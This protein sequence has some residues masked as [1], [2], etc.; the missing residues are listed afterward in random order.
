MILAGLYILYR[1]LVVLTNS[2]TPFVSRLLS[3]INIWNIFFG[4]VVLMPGLICILLADKFKKKKGIE[5]EN[6]KRI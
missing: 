1:Y 2:E 3:F 5:Y 4:L 6:G